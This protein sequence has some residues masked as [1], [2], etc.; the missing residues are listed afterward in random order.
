[1]GALTGP[2]NY[3]SGLLRAAIRVRET[4]WL[5]SGSDAAPEAAANQKVGLIGIDRFGAKASLL[6]GKRCRLMRANHWQFTQ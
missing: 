1:M 4:D 5:R 6:R 2:P 3:R